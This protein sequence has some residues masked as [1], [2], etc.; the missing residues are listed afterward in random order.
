MADIQQFIDFVAIAKLKGKRVAFW[1]WEPSVFSAFVRLSLLDGMETVFITDDFPVQ[2]LEAC[3]ITQDFHDIDELY[4]KPDKLLEFK[5]DQVCILHQDTTLAIKTYE[6]VLRQ[7]GLSPLDICVTKEIWRVSRYV[8]GDAYNRA[9]ASV[10]KTVVGGMTPRARLNLFDGLRYIT[11]N[12]IP[13]RIVNY[14]VSRGWS[15]YFIA[16]VLKQLGDTD[17]EIVAFDGFRGF[18]QDKSR[19]DLCHLRYKK[20]AL[21][22]TPASRENAQEATERNLEV[23]SKR[24]TLVAG[25]ICET[26]ADLGNEPVALALFDMD[27]YTPT[28]VTLEPTYRVLSKNG[29]FVLDHFTYDTTGGFC[30]GERVAMLEFLEKYPMF[31]PTGENIFYKTGNV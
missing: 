21:R 23:H 31:S 19:Y 14:G 8:E 13:G 15:V 30:I 29:V 10:P 17:R 24:I 25:D 16:E 26:I 5:P 28:K 27:D 22:S 4:S 7:F 9:I 6:T 1:G 3:K 20:Y 2:D 11:E 18:P 12:K